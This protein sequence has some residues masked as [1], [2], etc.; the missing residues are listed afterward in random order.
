MEQMRVADSKAIQIVEHEPD[1]KL[2]DNALRVL[3]K[4]YLKK[5]DRG[6]VIETPKE[7]FARVAWNLAQAERNYGADDAQVE[8]TARRFYRMIAGL[9]FLPNSP[10]LMNAGLELQQLSA[11]FAAGTP[12][13][14]SRG[15]VPIEEV[16]AG[17]LVLTHANRYRRVL[18]T[19]RREARVNRIRIH[20]LPAMVATDDHPFLTSQGWVKARELVGQYV[21]LGQPGEPL[22]RTAIEFD[23]E[24]EGDLVFGR[25]TG[26]SEA[27][28]QRHQILGTRSLQI[29]PV[30]ARVELDET[31]GWFLGMYLAE[32]E[33]NP[34][35]RAVRFTLGLHEEAQAERLVSILKHRFGVDSEI[36]HVIE[37]PTSWLTVRAHSKILCEWIAREFQRGFA[38]KRLPFWVH[39]TTAAFRAGLLQGVATGDGTRVNVHQ[40]RITLSNEPLV[41]QLFEVAV[42][43][44]HS[45]CLRPEYMPEN[46]TARPWSLT[47][48]G[49]P[50]YVRG[51]AYLVE[52]VEPVEGTTT[53]YNLE[54]EDDNTYV[55]N[56][57][58]VHNC[59]V[60]PVDDSLVG[61]FESLKHQALIHQSGG[62][63]GFSFSRLRPKGDFVKSTM[64]VASGPVSFMK[65]F[66]AAT[67]TVKQGGCISVDSL[68]RTSEG[69]KPLGRLL[70]SPPL[71]ENFT[72]DRVFDGTGFSHALVAQDNGP[73][74]IFSVEP[75]LG[76]RIGATYNHAFAVVDENGEVV[77]REAQDLREGDW[78]VIVKGG[79]LGFNRSLPPLGPQQ[80]NATRIRVPS[81]MNE[82]LAELLGLYMA[83]GCTSSGGRFIITIGTVDI[84]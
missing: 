70:N 12:I 8:E 1:P 40:T 46:A 11:C 64:G 37:A 75:E 25:K 6:R 74:E 76:L 69:L 4:R 41:R 42:E 71:G 30:R 2:T 58:V 82:D 20:R 31:V 47:L 32:G 9:E 65:I 43:L 83:D 29:K 73:A 7:L 59:F 44:G 33:I 36:T 50:M 27:S 15:P 16:V 21:R 62:G 34:E 61:I 77:W 49:R 19:M 10:T 23:G 53:V 52:S 13:S 54:V 68:L 67:Q 45:P 26:R 66:D 24:V 57:V 38:G 79:H 48:G 84:E 14:T 18:A 5:D 17:D 22:T 56:G 81:E 35:L 28:R 55:A 63:T 3:Q 78:L 51:G 39:S 60:L 80:P 72:R